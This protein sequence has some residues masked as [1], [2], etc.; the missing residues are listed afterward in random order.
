MISLFEIH[1][2]DLAFGLRLLQFE[3]NKR[4]TALF[5]FIYDAFGKRLWIDFCYFNWRIDL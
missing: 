3:N 1:F 4:D 2:N 5:S